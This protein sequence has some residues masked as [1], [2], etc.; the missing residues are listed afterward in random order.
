MINCFDFETGKQ[1]SFEEEMVKYKL[2][3]IATMYAA[4]PGNTS[5]EE[6]LFNALWADYVYKQN[7]YKQTDQLIDYNDEIIEIEEL[8]EQEMYD[9]SVGGDELFY[10]NQI[11]TK[12][13]A[14]LPATADLMI[15]VIETEETLEMGQQRVKQIKSRYGDKSINSSFMIAVDKGKQRWSDVE[16]N[17]AA[18]PAKS[19]NVSQPKYDTTDDT[20]TE[21]INW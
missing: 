9:I 21:G 16:S 8:D 4:I 14:G 3:N 19:K 6:E 5:T 13:S 20:L 12:N 1:L 17:I 10:A 15:A 7:L 2:R 11:L 18:T